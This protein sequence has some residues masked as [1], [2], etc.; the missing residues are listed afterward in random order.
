MKMLIE[1]ILT[2]VSLVMPAVAC[3]VA[4]DAPS[5]VQTFETYAPGTLFTGDNNEH[6]AVRYGDVRVFDDKGGKGNTPDVTMFPG[7]GQPARFGSFSGSQLVTKDPYK[8]NYDLELEFTYQPTDHPAE[9]GNSVVQM[10]QIELRKN[11]RK[12][13]DDG[14]TIHI[15]KTG[16]MA[17]WDGKV[18]TIPKYELKNTGFNGTDVFTL[19][20]AHS[21]KGLRFFVNGVDKGFIATTFGNSNAGYISFGRTSP[22]DYNSLKIKRISIGSKDSPATRPVETPRPAA[23][24]VPDAAAMAA[25]LASYKPL[26]PPANLP[27][28]V[29]TDACPQWASPRGYFDYYRLSKDRPFA[30]GDFQN[31]KRWQLQTLARELPSSAMIID[32][33]VGPPDGQGAA[34]IFREYLESAKGIAG[35]RVLP[36]CDIVQPDSAP[37]A[38][39]EDLAYRFFKD[40]LVRFGSNPNWLKLEG[41]PVIID[42]NF[43]GL[44]AQGVGRVSSRLAGDGLNFYWFGDYTQ[45]VDWTCNGNSDPAKRREELKYLSGFVSFTAPIRVTEG[46][47][48]AFA[49]VNKVV[50][51]FPER[52]LYGVATTPGHYSARMGQRNHVSARGTATMRDSLDAMLALRPAPAFISPQ[53]WNDYVEAAHFE[54]S[55]KHT[56]ALLEIVRSY[57]QSLTAQPHDADIQPHVIASYHKNTVAGSPFSF[58]LLNLPVAKPF[59][60]INATIVLRSSAGEILARL[61]FVLKGEDHMAQSVSWTPAAGLARTMV[62]VQVELAAESPK[63]KKTYLNLPPVPV[64]GLSDG[65]LVDLLTYSVPLHRLHV[66]GPVKLLVNGKPGVEQTISPRLLSLSADASGSKLSGIAYMR[67]G[68]VINDPTPETAQSAVLDNWPGDPSW[69]TPPRY[70]YYGTLAQF[71]DGSIAY[72]NGYVFADDPQDRVWADYYFKKEDQYPQVK[73][74]QDKLVD[75]SGR[76]I[77][78]TLRQ[79]VEGKGQSPQ[80][81]SVG[82]LHDALAFDGVSSAVELPI[83]AYPAGPLSIELMIKPADVNRVQNVLAQGGN[84]ASIRLLANGTL[85]AMRCNEV[86]KDDVAQGKTAIAAG[87]WTYVVV[88][89]D[90]SRLSLYVNG[91]LDCEVPSFGLRSIEGSRLGAPVWFNRGDSTGFYKGQIARFR[92]LQGATPAEQI[93]RDAGQLLATYGLPTLTAGQSR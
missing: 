93:S 38:E 8:G 65:Q 42:Y 40:L 71:E 55:F 48:N 63:F 13:Q 56:T 18:Q 83:T 89:F 75:R 2:L 34:N 51:E 52:R 21:D 60:A 19:R 23:A 10:M 85:S 32:L 28:I 43:G 86:R 41:V 76:S 69:P 53:T 7:S 84:A 12:G 49:N 90:G 5:F 58:E 46:D 68:A 77:H 27:L 11:D 37:A 39:R 62:D 9:L 22:R 73:M 72:S 16:E 79:A 80:W 59:G 35:S 31:P 78:G 91:K 4:P 87:A 6:L 29:L 30:V 47:F 14:L 17:M 1:K 70:E 44:T 36:M 92:I 66:S 64:L 88:T 61:P 54:P 81:E 74:G 25:L 67:S 15:Y 26:Q 33:V 24:V 82:L 45:Y 50:Q 3:A 57:T 20:I